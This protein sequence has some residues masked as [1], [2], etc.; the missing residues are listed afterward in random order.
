MENDEEEAEWDGSSKRTDPGNGREAEVEEGGRGEWDTGADAGAGKEREA[1]EGDA[2]ILRDKEGK[3]LVV[4]HCKKASDVQ[5]RSSSTIRSFRLASMKSRRVGFSSSS[6]SP[7]SVPS[8][9]FMVVITL[10]LTVTSLL[11]PALMA[12]SEISSTLLLKKRSPL[13]PS[14]GG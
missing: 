9:L 6:P 2:E 13:P 11:L 14:S 10:F 5:L 12:Q 4:I 8:Q 1:D 7:I 3:G